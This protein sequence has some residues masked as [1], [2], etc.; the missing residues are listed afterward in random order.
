MAIKFMGN[1]KYE[2]PMVSSSRFTVFVHAVLQIRK[3][4]RQNRKRRTNKSPE[5]QKIM[6]GKSQ[7][8]SKK[9]FEKEDTAKCLS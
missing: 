4:K 7:L 1:K 2:R 5:Q 6:A 8:F 3:Q 9:S